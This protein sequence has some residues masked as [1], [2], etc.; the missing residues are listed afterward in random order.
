MQEGGSLVKYIVCPKLPPETSPV[1]L[2]VDWPADLADKNLC[3][4]AQF[5]YTG[6]N[7][8]TTAPW[9]IENASR[10]NFYQTRDILSGPGPRQLEID[11]ASDQLYLWRFLDGK[12]S[13]ATKES[14]GILRPNPVVADFR[15][16]TLQSGLN[17]I[18]FE[19]GGYRLARL[20]ILRRRT[21][22]NGAF[23][24]ERFDVVAHAESVSSFALPVFQCEEFPDEMSPIG[25]KGELDADKKIGRVLLPP[26]YWL[27]AEHVDNLVKREFEIEA[28]TVSEW[29]ITV[30]DELAKV[31]RDRLNLKQPPEQK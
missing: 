5:V 12:S 27:E 13:P 9:R 23:K 7:L 31:I 2:R 18:E 26:S 30:P 28:G 22:Q 24:R 4:E 11:D 29:T 16:E 10:P 14:E 17:G 8:D 1:R 25:V 20:I 15:S 21:P 3:V 6:I 19:D